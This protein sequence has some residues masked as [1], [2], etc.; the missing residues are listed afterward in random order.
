MKTWDEIEG[1]SGPIVGFVPYEKLV[2]GIIA[3]A[4]IAAD[5]VTRVAE[6][7]EDGPPRASAFKVDEPEQDEPEQDE[8]EQDNSDA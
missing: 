1:D 8:P 4:Q 2:G 3:A 5:T 6:R 7:D